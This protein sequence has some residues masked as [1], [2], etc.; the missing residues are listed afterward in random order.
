MYNNKEKHIIGK[1]GTIR[2]EYKLEKYKIQKRK[3]MNRKKTRKEKG[4]ERDREILNT[5]RGER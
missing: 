4:K 1:I 3:R 5:G 2:C